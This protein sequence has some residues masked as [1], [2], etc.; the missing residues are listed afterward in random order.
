VIIEFPWNERADTRQIAA[1]L[2]TQFVKHDYQFRTVQFW[3]TEIRRGCQDLYD[4]I[5]GGRH[6]LDDFDGKF[7]ATLNKYL[8]ESAQSMAERLIVAYSTVL[9]Y[10]R[11]SLGLKSFHLHW[12]QHLL[13]DNLREKSKKMQEPYCHSC[14]LPNGMTGI[15]L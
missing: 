14:M 4:E 7:L 11:E 6:P 15:I 10:L 9:Q 13:T 1:R 2:Q 12:V 8:F 3:I 5:R